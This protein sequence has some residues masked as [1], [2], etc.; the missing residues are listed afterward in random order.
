MPEISRFLGL[1]IFMN[2]NDHTPPHF[3]AR[4]ND[5]EITV[6]IETGVITG[7]MPRRALQLVLEWLDQHK[8]EL[9]TNW[10]LAREHKPLSVIQ[11]LE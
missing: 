10:L 6:E 11:P 8:D 5:Y 9:H 4:Y 7:K 2:Y 3:H 1:V